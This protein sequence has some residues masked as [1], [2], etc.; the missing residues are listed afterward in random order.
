MAR[1][2]AELSVRPQKC[3]YVEQVGFPELRAGLNADLSCCF[4]LMRTRD[5]QF[6]GDLRGV[7]TPGK[8]RHVTGG[9]RVYRDCHKKELGRKASRFLAN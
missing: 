4:V 1:I 2:S 6:T 9:Q 5:F 7:G 8:M 3:Q